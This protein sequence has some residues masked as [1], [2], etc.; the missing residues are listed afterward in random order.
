MDAEVITVGVD[1]SKSSSTALGFAV[2]EARRRQCTLRV[3]TAWQPA[4]V[5]RVDGGSLFKEERAAY[6]KK[7]RELQDRAVRDV[8]GEGSELP[9]I[10]RMVVQGEPGGALVELSRDAA[11]LLVGTVHKGILKRAAVGSTSHY[12]VRHSRVPVV[13]V[14]FVTEAHAQDEESRSPQLEAGSGPVV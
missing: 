3:V 13:V 8:A 14:P 9:D 1:G 5:Y 7:A 10:E 11:L 6:E 12:C 4:T 2:E